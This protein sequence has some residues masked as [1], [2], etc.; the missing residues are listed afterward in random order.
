MKKLL[1]SS[2][3]VCS[4]TLSFAQMTADSAASLLTKSK[5]KCKF[6][7]KTLGAKGMYQCKADNYK[8]VITFNTD[9]KE[10]SNIMFSLDV[11]ELHPKFAEAQPIFTFF[12]IFDGKPAD[13]YRRRYMSMV[14]DEKAY[15]NT[16][17]YN[18]ADKKLKYTFTHDLFSAGE[19]GAKYLTAEINKQ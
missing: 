8:V 12:D 16:M 10:V 17:P 2:L 7:A 15:R 4:T 14:N 5:F 1:L 11:Q 18:D 19:H 13:Y 6:V 3:I 9:T